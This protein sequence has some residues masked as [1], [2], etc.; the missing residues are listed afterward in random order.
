[1]TARTILADSVLAAAAVVALAA[2]LA[3]AEIPYPMLH[4]MPFAGWM[5]VAIGCL[6]VVTVPS[7]AIAGIVTLVRRLVRR[8]AVPPEIDR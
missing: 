2:Y 3:S 6:L 5:A 4:D 7:L 8:D 1:M